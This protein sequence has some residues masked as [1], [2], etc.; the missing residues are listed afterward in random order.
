MAPC[1]SDRDEGQGKD[2]THEHN[3]SS[4]LHR[5]STYLHRLHIYGTCRSCQALLKR[6]PRL[7]F[8]SQASHDPFHRTT[9]M[10]GKKVGNQAGGMGRRPAVMWAGNGLAVQ[11]RMLPTQS[12]DRAGRVKR[13]SLPCAVRPRADAQMSLSESPMDRRGQAKPNR[14]RQGVYLTLSGHARDA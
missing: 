2:Q 13:E 3:A 10:C 11:I 9:G 5:I 7:D 14:P 4:S 12:A 1:L 8:H 6:R